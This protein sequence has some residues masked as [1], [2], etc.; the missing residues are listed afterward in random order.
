MNH[1]TCVRRLV[2]FRGTAGTPGWLIW[3]QFGFAM[4]TPEQDTSG[5]AGRNWEEKAEE[6]TDT[7]LLYFLKETRVD[8]PT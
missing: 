8:A 1:G 6:I 3:D 4:N 7:E 2:V 5:S